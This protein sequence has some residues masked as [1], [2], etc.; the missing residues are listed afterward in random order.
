MCSFSMF[1]RLNK[2]FA[3]VVVASL[4][5]VFSSQASAL[6]SDLSLLEQRVVDAK[7]DMIELGKDMHIF[8][9][10]VQH[11]D[12]ERV[13]LFLSVDVGEFFTLQ[14]LKVKMDGESVVEKEFHHHEAGG[15]ES[16]AAVRLFVGSYDKG[17]HKLVAFVKGRGPR[18]IVVK[19]GV[20][21]AFKKRD[22]AVF[23]ELRVRDLERRLQPELIVKEW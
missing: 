3:A 1:Y 2:C 11:P 8:E 9:R 23:L 14:S 21:H 5:G 20:V 6:T 16:G 10:M 15:L 7:R 22:E 18:G 12:E 4:A 17:P 19:K 13:S